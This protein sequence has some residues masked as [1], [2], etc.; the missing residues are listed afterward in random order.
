M[1]WHL[2]SIL[3]FIITFIW[4]SLLVELYNGKLGKLRELRF[5]D[6]TGSY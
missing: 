5:R 2:A 1:F 6:R 3:S 4:G